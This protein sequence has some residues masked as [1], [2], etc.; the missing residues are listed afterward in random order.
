MGDTKED[1]E[2]YKKHSDPSLDFFSDRFDAALALQ[3][4]GLQPPNPKVSLTCTNHSM[5]ERHAGAFTVCLLHHSTVRVI[6]E[7]S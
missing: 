7:S 5:A 6:E 1:T 2:R 4:D 3:S